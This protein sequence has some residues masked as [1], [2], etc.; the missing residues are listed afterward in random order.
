MPIEPSMSV[1]PISRPR[2]ANW[3]SDSNW[4]AAMSPKKIAA[5][6]VG[7]T[8]ITIAEFIANERDARPPRDIPA[9]HP[10]PLRTVSRALRAAS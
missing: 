1:G 4:S 6:S 5:R 10:P 9:C 2:T 3:L 8:K 7:T